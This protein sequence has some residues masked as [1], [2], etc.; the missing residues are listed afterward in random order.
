LGNGAPYSFKKFKMHEESLTKNT[1]SV[2]EA[3]GASGIVKNFYL[4]GG[5]ALALYF[6]H[7]FSVDLNWFAEK[8]RYTPSFR[9][10]LEKLGKIEIGSESKNTFNGALNGVKISFLEYPYPLIESKEQYGKN[11]YLA[12]VPDI[13]AMKLEAVSSRG[14]Y[15]DFIDIYFLKALTYFKDAEGTA[16]PEL[17]KPVS[18][19]KVTDTI[20]RKT[21]NYLKS[22]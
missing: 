17:I 3:L 22:L 10:Q 21:E 4:A 9:Q 8:F 19:R 2:L 13:A 11:I 20:R 16:M 12:S 18:W 5:S 7:R 14:S 6:G 1:K 15:K